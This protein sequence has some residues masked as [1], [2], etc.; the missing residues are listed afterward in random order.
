MEERFMGWRRSDQKFL[1]S[2]VVI[3]LCFVSLYRVVGSRR[4]PWI[5]LES[6][7]WRQLASKPPLFEVD[8]NVADWPELMLLPRIGERLGQRIVAERRLRRGFRTENELGEIRGIGSKSLEAVRPF[9]VVRSVD[10]A[11]P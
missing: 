11:M 5:S 10:R 3:L 2:V 4:A 6:P 9:I 1:I 7:A 8:L